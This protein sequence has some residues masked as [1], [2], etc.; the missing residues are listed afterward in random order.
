MSPQ[1]L[2]LLSLMSGVC[3]NVACC[4]SGVSS[5]WTFGPVGVEGGVSCAAGGVA[6]RAGRIGRTVVG[7]GAIGVESCDGKKSQSVLCDGVVVG[8]LGWRLR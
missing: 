4:V 3:N 7:A 2:L 5:W 1:G 8:F 6:E